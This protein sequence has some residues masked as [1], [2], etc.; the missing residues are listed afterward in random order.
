MECLPTSLSYFIWYTILTAAFLVYD[1]SRNTPYRLSL[2]ALLILALPFSPKVTLSDGSI[3]S[4]QITHTQSAESSPHDGTETEV[5]GYF[6]L[7]IQAES[8]VSKTTF[9]FFVLRSLWEI[10][11]LLKSY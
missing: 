2:F 6:F 10:R 3:G 7:L 11:I 1:L 8:A 5:K 9:G 4:L